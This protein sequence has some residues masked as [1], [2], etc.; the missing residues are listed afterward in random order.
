MRVERDGA[1]KVPAN[2]ELVKMP[3]RFPSSPGLYHLIIRI[4]NAEN[5]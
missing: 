2:P 3:E 1:H 5:D 4:A